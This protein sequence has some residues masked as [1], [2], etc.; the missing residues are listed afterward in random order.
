MQE[1]FQRASNIIWDNRQSETL[2]LNLEGKNQ[3]VELNSSATLIWKWTDGSNSIS[4]ISKKLAR[5]YNISY[6]SAYTDVVEIF[7]M[8]QE[9]ELVVLNSNQTMV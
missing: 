5:H 6:Q 1:V 4:E 3:F 9:D 7:E 8:W 2:I